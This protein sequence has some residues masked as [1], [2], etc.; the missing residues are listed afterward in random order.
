M[1]VRPPRP[2][3]AVLRESTLDY[4]VAQEQASAL[5]RLG[6][7][8]EAALAALFLHDSAPPEGQPAAGAE[9][10]RLVRAASQALWCFV[11]QREACGLRDQ[12]LMLREYAVP[13]E[14]QNRMGSLG[15]DDSSRPVKPGFTVF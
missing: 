15:S 5:G 14:V 12:R 9:R 13:T 10:E 7:I 11:V 3:T 1:I 6:R 4:E 8:L 2:C